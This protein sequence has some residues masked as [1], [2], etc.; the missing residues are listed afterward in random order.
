MIHAADEITA[1]LAY[2]H[3]LAQQPSSSLRLR[4]LK[5]LSKVYFA[6]GM[7]GACRLHL[8][9]CMLLQVV[10]VHAV[11]VDDIEW[12]WD[13]SNDLLDSSVPAEREIG[14]QASAK[15]NVASAQLTKQHRASPRC[16][17]RVEYNT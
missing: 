5:T 9:L 1:L 16:A 7:P 12:L 3:T 17:H 15:A 6:R 2:A 14:W 11:S 8:A 13:S 4:V 10:R